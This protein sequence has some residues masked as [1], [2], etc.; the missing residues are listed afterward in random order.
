MPNQ[1]E[2]TGNMSKVDKRFDSLPTLTKAEDFEEWKRDVLIWK[3]ITSI[4]ASKQGPVLY[5]SLDG[6]AKKVC[7][8]I[9]VEDIC[10]A[11]GYTLIMA[12]L[13]EVFAKDKE[14]ELFNI[15]RE[16]E[17]FKRK[18]EMSINEYINEFERLYG[19][20]KNPKKCVEY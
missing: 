18:P 17:T 4:E 19:K 7:S 14:Q 20:I 1:K 11:D 9:K 5:R 16:F 12:K 8:N 13:E 2:N 15:C 10:G 6:Q 3:E